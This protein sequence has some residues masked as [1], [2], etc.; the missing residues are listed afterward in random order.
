MPTYQTSTDSTKDGPVTI[1]YCV[2]D[3]SG[4][5]HVASVPKAVD[6]EE[7]AVALAV[8]HS[9]DTGVLMQH[10]TSGRYLA[11]RNHWLVSDTKQRDQL[12][13]DFVRMLDPRTRLDLVDK[14]SDYAKV[15]EVAAEIMADMPD[16]EP[17]D[18]SVY[19][20]DG[21]DGWF[22]VGTDRD[23]GYVARFRDLE[24]AQAYAR[25]LPGSGF[26]GGP[27]EPAAG[28]VPCWAHC[29]RLGERM[30]GTERY[31]LTIHG[32]EFDLTRRHMALLRN[33]LNSAL[34]EPAV[35]QEVLR[36]MLS[37]EVQA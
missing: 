10:T 3:G 30:T 35:S 23:G 32:V 5:R 14:L 24:S 11:S 36:D 21:D 31:D 6:A 13:G 1:S 7:I 33:M 17:G 8:V 37:E 22:S 2:G 18:P 19:I 25:T 28:E 15:E 27:D 16:P 26:F 20:D 29:E 12:L 4:W 34:T 9:T